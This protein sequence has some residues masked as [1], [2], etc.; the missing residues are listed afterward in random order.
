MA[1]SG[2]KT[3]SNGRDD[4]YRSCGFAGVNPENTV[5]TVGPGERT[6]PTLADP[7][8]AAT[9]PLDVE[10]KHPGTGVAR[11]GSPPADRDTVPERWA[12]F[13]DRVCETVGAHDARFA[14]FYE[15]A[16]AVVRE[17]AP[18]ACLAA[19]CCGCAVA[20]NPGES[21]PVGTTPR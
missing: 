20:S 18:D 16:L 1:S 8:R 10:L 12:T 7:R 6:V 14:P 19:L 11:R 17:R 15:G 21:S 13:V 9:V 5:A 3:D 4:R 2:G